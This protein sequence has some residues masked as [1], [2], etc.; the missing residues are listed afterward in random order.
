MAGPFLSRA[1]KA[2][3]EAPRVVP[4]LAI[5]Q[6]G[7][8]LGTTRFRVAKGPGMQGTRVCR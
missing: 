4:K 3:R 6:N 5:S 7:G 8:T 1:K 2:R